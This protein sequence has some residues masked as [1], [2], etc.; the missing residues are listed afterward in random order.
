VNKQWIELSPKGNQHYDEQI[1]KSRTITRQIVSQ[2]NAKLKEINCLQIE[3]AKLLE[4][5]D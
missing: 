5:M 2:L 1:N 3:N 4:R